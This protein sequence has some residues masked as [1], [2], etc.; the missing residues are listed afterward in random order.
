MAAAPMKA[1]AR[2]VGSLRSAWT[3]ST[4]LETQ[5]RAEGEE[6]LRVIPRTF[7][8]GSLEKRDATDPP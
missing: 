5:S 8:P 2:V 3:I 7:Q 1:V 4:S 6:G